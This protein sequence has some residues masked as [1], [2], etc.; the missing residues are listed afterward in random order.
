MDPQEWKTWISE[1]IEYI[2][3]PGD[4]TSLPTFKPEL[5]Q[6]LLDD[7]VRIYDKEAES[8]LVYL[9]Y[10]IALMT[11]QRKTLFTGAHWDVRG[12]TVFDTWTRDHSHGSSP[13]LTM[14]CAHSPH[15]HQCMD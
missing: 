13:L 10:P 3:I 11:K 12:S 8:A 5:R 14:A 9:G 15:T 1:K 2:R 6:A 4:S 7:Q